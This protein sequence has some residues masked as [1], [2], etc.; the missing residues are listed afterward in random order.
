MV[1]LD[2]GA[3]SRLA[4]PSRASASLLAEMKAEGHW[5]LMVP[6]VVLVECL[7]GRAG[8]DAETNRFLKSCQIEP[9][10]P[11][12]RARRAAQLR[13]LAGRGSAVDAVL[14]AAAEP[15]GTVYTGDEDDL[16]ALAAHSVGVRVR[17]I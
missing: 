10:L 2:G 14:V 9:G 12:P 6:T 8:F 11:A 16:S 4:E 13:R 1:V 15:N 5:P 17:R 3:V 7:R